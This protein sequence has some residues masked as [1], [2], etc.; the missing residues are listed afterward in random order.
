METWCQG[1]PD[2]T[3][4]SRA[5]TGPKILLNSFFSFLAFIHGKTFLQLG[6]YFNRARTVCSADGV[7]GALILRRINIEVQECI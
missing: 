2:R 5:R 6:R 7:R 3:E 1:R 4:K